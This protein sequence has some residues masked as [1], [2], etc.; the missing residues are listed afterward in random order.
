MTAYKPKTYLEI[1]SGGTTCFAR[2]AI[3]DHS[4]ATKIISID[5]DPRAKI[6]SIC[7]QVFFKGLENVDLSIFSSL[8]AGDI[9][10]MDGSHRT[11]MNSD[12]TVFMLEVLPHLKPGVI[13]HIHDILLPYDY[14]DNF[15]NWYWNEQYM[16]ALYLIA[17]KERI[18]VIFPS[19]YVTNDEKFAAELHNPLFESLWGHSREGG[20]IW[21]THSEDKK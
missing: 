3:Q 11:F 21:F 19:A 2:R 14:P 16:V 13:V 20:S 18:D 7:D 4:L 9:V 15:K 12:V 8:E 1:G 5:P 10:F 17:A 6:E